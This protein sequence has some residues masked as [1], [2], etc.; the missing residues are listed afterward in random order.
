M[1][2]LEEV[3]KLLDKELK[4]FNKKIKTISDKY[5]DISYEHELLLSDIEAL[6]NRLIFVEKKLKI[7]N[8]DDN[9]KYCNKST[10]NIKELGDFRYQII[11]RSKARQLMN[12]QHLNQNPE[13]EELNINNT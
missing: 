3:K 2:I 13:K 6:D 12:N 1:S 9:D 8:D 7:S 5:E 10:N 11:T 4:K